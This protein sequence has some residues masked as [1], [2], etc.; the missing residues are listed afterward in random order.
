MIEGFGGWGF[1]SY[2]DLPDWQ[3]QMNR[4]LGLV[5]QDKAILAQQYVNAADINDRM[6]LLGSYLLIKGR[7]TYLNLDLDL[8]PEW[9][10]EYGIPIGSPVGGIPANVDA[11]WD[12]TWGV[13]TRTYSNG[14]ALVNPT[15]TTQT[16][17]LGGTYYRAT[18]NGG[19]FVPADGDVSAWMVTYTP[20][21]SV[22]LAPNQAAVLLNTAP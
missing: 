16:V 22:E 20:V 4:I 10:P 5:G 1:A 12:E 14:L 13:Y 3:L 2:F 7:Y 11:L 9:F 6:F 17:A 8:D 19:G 18:P 15:T 21:T